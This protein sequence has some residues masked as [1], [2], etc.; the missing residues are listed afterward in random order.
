MLNIVEKIPHLSL[1]FS[2]QAF[3]LGPL[4]Y[5]GELFGGYMSHC[6]IRFWEGLNGSGEL[7]GECLDPATNYFIDC[8]RGD[9]GFQPNRIH[10]ISMKNIPKFTKVTLIDKL[11]ACS[12]FNYVT[13]TVLEDL[14]ELDGNVIIP[15][16]DRAQFTDNWKIQVSPGTKELNTGST[17]AGSCFPT[18]DELTLNNLFIDEYTS[19]IQIN[20]E[21]TLPVKSNLKR[22]GMMA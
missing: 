14:L 9:M 11:Y 22:F 18:D 7:I 2:A 6:Y 4:I 8:R 19:V 16:L 12:Q 17:F 15:T 3:N 21:R 1:A 20:Y 5:H 13:V 10:S